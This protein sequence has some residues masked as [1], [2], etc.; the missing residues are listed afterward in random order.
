MIS[1]NREA[2]SLICTHTL[3]HVLRKREKEEGKRR[4]RRS[5]FGALALM[6]GFGL[7]LSYETLFF[8]HCIMVIYIEEV[9]LSF[10]LWGF[11]G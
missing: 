3:T 10:S 4:R 6:L 2:P 7:A 8:R 9:F 5:V 1:I 11:L